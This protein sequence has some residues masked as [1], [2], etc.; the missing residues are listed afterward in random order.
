MLVASFL[1]A[2]L[3]PHSNPQLKDKKTR[4]QRV[5]GTG[6]RGSHSRMM[7]AEHCSQRNLEQCFLDA[8]NSASGQENSDG[9]ASLPRPHLEPRAGLVR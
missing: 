6:P 1:G 9:L 7:A 2:N 8:R 4:A 5:G 3:R